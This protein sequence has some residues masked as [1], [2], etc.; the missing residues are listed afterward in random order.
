MLCS[1]FL[2]SSL[3]PSPTLEPVPRA[4]TRV[5]LAG[6]PAPVLTLCPAACKGVDSQHLTEP[7]GARLSVPH[8]QKKEPGL[9][10]A[11][12]LRQVAELP[13]Y[14]GTSWC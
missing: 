10:E 1:G 2:K 6:T 8:L 5:L 7:S 13:C 9:R 11:E 4:R 14:Y 12:V 3:S